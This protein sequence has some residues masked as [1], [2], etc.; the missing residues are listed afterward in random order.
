MMWYYVHKRLTLEYNTMTKCE[1]VNFQLKTLFDIVKNVCYLIFFA[2]ILYIH[3][4][5]YNI[6]SFI[7][8][9]NIFLLCKR[10]I[11]ISCD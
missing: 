3:A 8:V 6:P 1:K 10:H 9:N 7:H 5:C 2:F 4:F 11:A